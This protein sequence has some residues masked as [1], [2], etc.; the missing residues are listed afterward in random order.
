MDKLIGMV[1][2]RLS[3]EEGVVRNALGAVLS[4]LKNQSAGSFDFDKIISAVP[5]TK[6]LMEK[7]PDAEEAAASR[8]TGGGSMGGLIGMVFTLL[9]TF[10]VMAILKNLLST[11]F[12]EGAVKMLESAGDGAELSGLLGNLGVSRDQGISMTQ[13]LVDFMKEKV[14]PETID[15]LTDSIPAVKAFLG[16]TKKAE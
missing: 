5:G 4:F 9:K 7:A 10:G 13:M 1:S 11:F 3:L 8:S 6:E 16:E 12:G 2:E 14:S 15:Q